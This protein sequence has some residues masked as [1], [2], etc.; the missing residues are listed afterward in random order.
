[1]G[2][3][4]IAFVESSESATEGNCVVAGW[5]GDGVRLRDSRD[6]SGPFLRFTEKEWVAFAD[7]VR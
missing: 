1:M 6:P 5:D 3:T 2:C 4:T 7:G